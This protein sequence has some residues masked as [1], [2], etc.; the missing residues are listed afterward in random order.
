MEVSRKSFKKKTANNVT[1][2]SIQNKWS[3]RLQVWIGI[4]RFRESC[5]NQCNNYGR[6]LL[7]HMNSDCS[8]QRY[9]L[10]LNI[11]TGSP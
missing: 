5:P 8:V 10:Y 3:L 6:I 9:Y 4:L 2:I 1:T 11:S 7:L